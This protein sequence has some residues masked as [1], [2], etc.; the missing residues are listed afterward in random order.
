VPSSRIAQS[1]AAQEARIRLLGTSAR[2]GFGAAAA[3]NVGLAEARG[4]FVAFLDADDLFLPD[5]ME[6]GL[7]LAAGNPSAALICGAARWW[8]PAGES[9][10][11][12]DG[13]SRIR[14]GLYQ[15]PH[16]LDQMMLLQR[17]QVPCTCAILARREAVVAAGGFEETLTL[18]EDQ[19]LLARLLARYPAYIGTHL[20]SLYRQHSESTSA[21]AQRAGDYHRLRAHPARTAFL[22]WL[23]RD[24]AAFAVPSTMSALR[25]A[26]AMLAGDWKQLSPAERARYSLLVLGKFRRRAATKFRRFARRLLGRRASLPPVPH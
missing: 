24:L 11:W 4:D 2:T 18:Y 10:D 12:I 23:A 17:D 25:I 26:R 6:T 21:R 16:L 5:A 9:A 3:R 8:H 22:D 7:A 19:T 13:I 14:P 1:F 20:T 15:P